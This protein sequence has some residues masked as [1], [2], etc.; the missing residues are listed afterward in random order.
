MRLRKDF[1]K[2]VW[3]DSKD[4]MKGGSCDVCLVP[5]RALSLGSGGLRADLFGWIATRSQCSLCKQT[6]DEVDLSK[7][8]VDSHVRL[9]KGVDRPFYAGHIPIRMAS[10]NKPGNLMQAVFIAFQGSTLSVLNQL[11]RSRQNERVY[12]SY[13]KWTL[14]LLCRR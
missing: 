11:G 1:D 10:M 14:C 3:T 13:R 7:L 6:G 4:W 2:V 5:R 8:P 9:A 12:H